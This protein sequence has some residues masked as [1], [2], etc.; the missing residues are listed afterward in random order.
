[1]AIKNIDFIFFSG[2]NGVDYP[3]GGITSFTRQMMS[4]FGNR[5]AL[6][7][8]ST[9][10]TPAG[11]W[12][13]KDFEGESYLFFSIA[14]VD[15]D[16]IKPLLPLRLTTYFQ[17]KRYRKAILSLNI[18]NAIVQNSHFLL[19]IKDW[20]IANKAYIFHGVTNPLEKA[21]YRPAKL[22]APYYEEIMFKRLMSYNTI[23]TVA[24]ENGIQN[25]IS[26][27]KNKFRRDNFIKLPT[28]FDNKT[29][30][31]VAKEHSMQCLGLDKDKTIF[32][33]VG[34]LS[35]QKGCDFIID[36]FYHFVKN[37]PDSE[38]Y[39]VGDGEAKESIQKKISSLGLSGN[40]KITGFKSKQEVALFYNSAD[41]VLV[42]S[43]MEG[44]SVAMVEALACG[45]NIVSTN[46]SGAREMILPGENGYIVNCRDPRLFAK[47]MGEALKLPVHN[48]YSI[49]VSENFSLSTL[50]DDIVNHWKTT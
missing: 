13:Y 23:F 9:D 33:Q 49:Q 7:G 2:D 3:V 6:V 38:L 31:P 30:Y 47:K 8:I 28:R 42:G 26:R 18:S 40:V 15:R 36:S 32:V 44:W 43:H 12:V 11:K 25:M 35:K 5:M 50:K 19:A 48:E 20:P 17:L 22:L 24:D 16:K 21:R 29:F 10:N 34:R 4:V 46:V 41:L 45:K 1:M 14:R 39:L 37:N 27:S